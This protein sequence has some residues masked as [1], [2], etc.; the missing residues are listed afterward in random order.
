MATIADLGAE[1]SRQHRDFGAGSLIV[2]DRLVRIYIAAGI[3]VQALQGLDLLVAT[4]PCQGMSSSNPGRGKRGTKSA[5]E[6]GQTGEYKGKSAQGSGE[7]GKSAQG[8]NEQKGKT[9]QEQR[10]ERNEKGAQ[11]RNENEN[12]Q[13]QG[14]N[15]TDRNAQI[16]RTESR[17]NATAEKREGSE[18]ANV[19]VTDEQKTRIHD[20]VVHDS[21]IRKV[22]RSNIHFSLNVGT[23]I[24]DSVVFYDAPPELISIDAALRGYKVIVLEDGVV[25]IVDPETREI[26]D[27]IEV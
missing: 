16:N 4:P 17:G 11:N 25:L 27:V 24:P 18:H 15:R 21:G 5:Q 22:S 13:V 1:A 26:V 3:E 2:C 9:A 6:H 14:E 7:Q 20:V 23:R 8:A 19:R 10:N 12:K